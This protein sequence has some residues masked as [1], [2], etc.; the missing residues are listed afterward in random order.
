MCVRRQLK[1]LEGKNGEAFSK[2][3]YWVWEIRR[4]LLI[5]IC[6]SESLLMGLRW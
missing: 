5:M 3:I 2:P 1:N 6:G 4:R